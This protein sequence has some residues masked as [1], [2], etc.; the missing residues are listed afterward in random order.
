MKF[1]LTHKSNI[2][3]KVLFTALLTVSMLAMFTQPTE[4]YNGTLAYQVDFNLMS[5]SAVSTT[6]QQL[7]CTEVTFSVTG[8][9][10]SGAKSSTR[11][12]KAVFQGSLVN[13]SISFS[14][15]VNFSFGLYNFNDPSAN[16]KKA[17]NFSSTPTN[18]TLN[19]NHFWNGTELTGGGA[20]WSA[21]SFFEYT[22]TSSLTFD[23]GYTSGPAADS[24]G[25]TGLTVYCP[26]SDGDGLSDDLEQQNGTSINLVDTD[27]DG[28]NDGLELTSET[29]PTDPLN[30][31]D[32]DNS[33]PLCDYD[34]DGLNNQSEQA[35]GTKVHN[36]DSD[37]D[38]IDDNQE[39]IDGADPLDEC[40]PYPIWEDCDLDGDGLNNSDEVLGETDVN[41]QDSDGDGILDGDED[42]FAVVDP[43]N[44]NVNSTACKALIEEYGSDNTCTEKLPETGDKDEEEQLAQTGSESQTLL[45]GGLLISM[46]AIATAYL[47]LYNSPTK[48]SGTVASVDSP[49]NLA[50]NSSRQTIKV[51]QF[52]SISVR[53]VK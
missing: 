48:L 50:M 4:A 9:S 2:A 51:L 26:D 42:Q 35:N 12:R 30:G 20:V 5:G 52:R 21:A 3:K 1:N 17:D 16:G 19:N 43:C 39:I 41:S 29:N 47:T 38:N 32:P 25:V 24:I 46:S 37:G 6:T 7:S 53:E 22:A 33:L 40:N 10:G 45:V 11:F 34:G 28:F 15:P 49:S 18:V 27:G 13:V 8:G 36:Q 44:P 23:Y 14:Q 31:C